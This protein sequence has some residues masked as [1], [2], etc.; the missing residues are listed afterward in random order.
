MKTGVI[1]LTT[2]GLFL[3]LSV[4]GCFLGKGDDNEKTSIRATTKG[5]ELI[6]LQKAWDQGIITTEEYEKQRKKILDDK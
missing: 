4:S 3:S 1:L 2:I 5:Q 6:D